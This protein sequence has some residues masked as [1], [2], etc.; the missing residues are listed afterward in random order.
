[1]KIRVKH[2]NTEIEV[3]DG[4]IGEK[5]LLYHNESYSKVMLIDVVNSVKEI[6]EAENEIL[7]KLDNE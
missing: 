1:M 5:S 7:K 6:I 2:R 4:G 3:S